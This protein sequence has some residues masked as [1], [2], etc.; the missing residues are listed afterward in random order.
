MSNE[1]GEDFCF[2]CPEYPCAK[3]KRLDK[4]YAK[5]YGLSVLE[6]LHQLEVL[7]LDR[8]VD[9][10]QRQWSCAGCGAILCMHKPA[11]KNCGK[12]WRK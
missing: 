12:V 6:N 9:E 10:Q 3:I 4:R 5:S 1:N 2:T 8:F 11:C 7:G